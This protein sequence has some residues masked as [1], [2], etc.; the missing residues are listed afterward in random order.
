MKV[1]NEVKGCEFETMVSASP[2]QK[3]FDFLHDP[4]VLKWYP[5]TAVDACASQY[6]LGMWQVFYSS[7]VRAS[8]PGR[9]LDFVH[10]CWK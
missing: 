8:R 10:H 9:S 5:P 7:Q 4:E 2:C 1:H 6:L 3:F